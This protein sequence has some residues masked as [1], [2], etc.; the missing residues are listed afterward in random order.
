MEGWLR[1]TV[2]SRSAPFR[3][4]APIVA[5]LA[6]GAILLQEPSGETL[7][8][9]E[10]EE[11][12]W[13]FPKGHVDAGESLR[14]AAL[15]EIREETGL[16]DVQLERELV[17]V[18]YRFFSPGKERNV[19]KTTVYFLARTRERDAHPE[20]IFDRAEWVDLRTA[21]ARVR[22]PTDRQVLDVVLRDRARAAEGSSRSSTPSRSREK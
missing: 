13:C 20:P 22:F 21:R 9:H 16:S 19:H 5:E 17:E 7:L 10:K 11:D 6:A 18:S 2:P 1:R 14:E 4:D 8:L 12:R 15:R 3:P